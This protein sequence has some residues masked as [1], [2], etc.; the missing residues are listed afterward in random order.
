MSGLVK[1]ALTVMG[2][3]ALWVLALAVFQTSLIFPRSL[4]GA[5]P[6]LPMATPLRLSTPDGVELHGYRIAGRNPRAP[7]LLGFGGNATHAGVV[8]LYL[9]QLAPAH[10]VVVYHY[11]GYGP[12]TGRPSAQAL[13]ADAQAIHDNLD[14]AGGIVAVGFSIGSGITAHL[15]ALRDLRGMVLVTPF[16]DLQS[17][18]QDVLPVVPVRLFF[19]HPMRPLDALRSTD[20]PLA[21]FI[22]LMDEVIPPARADAL[23]EGLHEAGRAAMVHTLRAGHD[24]IYNNAEFQRLLRATLDGF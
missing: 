9:H 15:G 14:A 18:A 4:I 21:I 6:A 20:T 23:V 3:Y 1:L 7:V 8:A 16:D 24:D 13:I 5:G 11:R 19:R 12:S 17:V 2:L 10:D 22:A